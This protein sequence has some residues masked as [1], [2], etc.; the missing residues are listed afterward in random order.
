MNNY[1]DLIYDIQSKE[2][3]K[4]LYVLD[5]NYLSYAMQLVNSW[6]DFFKAMEKVQ[7][8]LYIPFVVYI[9]IIDNISIHISSTEKRLQEFNTAFDAILNL[10]Q[11]F[12]TDKKELNKYLY[13]KVLSKNSNNL[14][15]DINFKSVAKDQIDSIID[16]ICNSL[17]NQ[18]D[19]L[20]KQLETLAKA[21]KIDI[22]KYNLEEYKNSIP[23]R[24]Q[25]LNNI[26]TRENVVGKEYT[27]KELEELNSIINERFE[28]SIP[29]GYKDSVKDSKGN[30]YRI[31]GSLIFK[32]SHG[33]PMFWLDIIKFVKDSDYDRVVIVSD[34]TK[35]DW[36]EKKGESK[37][38]KELIIEFAK[39][40]GKKVS[41]KKCIDFVKDIL[42]LTDSERDNIDEEITDFVNYEGVYEPGYGLIENEKAFYDTIIVRA[43][44]LNFKKIFLEE[45]CWYSVS[46]D[47]SRVPY[48]KY[49]AV[50]LTFPK[51]QITHYAK[52][53]KIISSPYD[54]DKKMI[55]F[56]DDPIPLPEPI[57]L[58]DDKNAMQNNRYTHFS[59]LF[60]SPDIDAMLYCDFE[61]Y[62]SSQIFNLT[63]NDIL[64]NLGSSEELEE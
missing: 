64:K 24:L 47:E 19:S 37:L 18:V 6:N 29:P 8:R 32:K 27:K 61:F 31:F 16:R 51:S 7:D 28:N 35:T 20:N 1:F 4:I 21:E 48:L 46:I 33:D 17:L 14:D 40:T 63:N 58:G 43:K 52:I 12:D 10:K 15:S 45:K 30:P 23:Q 22:S 57:P 56:E 50:Y 54:S 3:E 44:P 38:R 59:N 36:S 39:E 34:D 26:F 49:I 41:R 60:N 62:K 25:K 2:D 5:T 42:S 53:K 13:K 11:I 55:I 9:E